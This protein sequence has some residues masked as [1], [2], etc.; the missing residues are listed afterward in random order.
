MEILNLEYHV[1]LLVLKAMNKSKKIDDAAPLL[2][3][4]IRQVFHYK[5]HYAINWNVEKE[6]YHFSERSIMNKFKRK[7]PIPEKA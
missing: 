2:G 7:N 5:K 1:G 4:S 6:C 3:V